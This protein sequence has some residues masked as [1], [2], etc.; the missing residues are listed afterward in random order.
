MHRCRLPSVSLEATARNDPQ[1]CL[2]FRN[3][4]AEPGCPPCNCVLLYDML[5]YFPR[6]LKAEVLRKVFQALRPGGHLIV[7]DACAKE[8]SRHSRVAR[9][10][11][12]GSAA[13]PEQNPSRIA[14]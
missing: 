9:S 6:E 5:H 3:L 8:T 12:L 1:L 11:K 10:E 13:G 7:R 2:E 4:L 14:F